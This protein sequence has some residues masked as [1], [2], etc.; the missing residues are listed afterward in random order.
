[1]P[2][3]LRLGRHMIALNHDTRLFAH[4]LHL[5]YDFTTVV[6][7]VDR[8]PA[9]PTQWGLRNAGTD[10]WETTAPGSPSRLVQPGRAVALQ[11]GLRIDFGARVGE[12]STGPA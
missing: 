1:M 2:P 7:E 4:H 8:N 6:A 10:T 11:A 5:D 12:V 3:R 9:N